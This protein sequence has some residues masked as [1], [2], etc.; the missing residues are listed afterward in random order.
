MFSSLLQLED[1]LT[2]VPDL[3]KRWEIS[4]DGLTYDFFLRDDVYFHKSPLFGKDST[5]TVVANDFVYSFDRLKDAKVASPGGWVLNNVAQYSAINDSIFRIRL[6]NPFPAFLGLMTMQYVAV[7]PHEV[8]EHFGNDFRSHPIGTGPFK[9]KLWEENVKLVMRRNEL[10]YEKDDKGQQLPYLE[11][12]AVT[13]LPDKQSEF[14]QFAQ[15]NIDFLNSLDNSYIDEILTADGKLREKYQEEVNMQKGPFLNTEFLGFYLDSKTPAVNS[16]LIRKAVNYGFDR[17]K[18]MKYL[19][20]SVGYPAYAGFI[21]KGMPG[22]KDIVYYDYQPKKAKALI[23]EYKALTGDQN[24][25][26]AIGT[27]SQ[28]QDFCEYIQRELGKLGL[29]I[30][31]EVMPAP[32]LRQKKSSGQLDVFRGS[33]IADYPDPENYLS[34]FYTPNFTPN[35][36][37]YTHFSDPAFDPLFE[38]SF[39]ITDKKKREALYTKMDSLVMSKAP[40]V[41]LYYD[42]VVRFTRKNVHGLGI[43]PIN[44]LTLKKVRKTPRSDVLIAKD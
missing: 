27:N 8:A 12:I 25:S 26:I 44:L 28:Y 1:D 19:R 35:G 42:E 6:K 7:V 2:P 4:E 10:Y 14:L 9:F 22:Y 16:E 13:F 24:P 3:A 32:T 39:T 41:P 20:N 18:M 31:V 30:A 38:R 15:G 40:V 36:P 17:D 11:A 29:E 43:N 34:V 33:W 37:N 21:P 23:E 5:R